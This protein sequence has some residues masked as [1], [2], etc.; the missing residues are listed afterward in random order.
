MY[1]YARAGMHIATGAEPRLLPTQQANT[2]NRA[3]LAHHNMN[4]LAQPL[5]P[6]ERAARGRR[7][8]TDG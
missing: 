5:R 8:K 4:V 1:T 7:Q 3:L 6:R 2:T